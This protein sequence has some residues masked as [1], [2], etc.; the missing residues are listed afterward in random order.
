MKIPNPLEMNDWDIRKFFVIFITLYVIF[1]GIFF[2]DKL[3]INIPIVEE[4]ITI[5]TLIFVPGILFLRTLRLHKL[6]S[7]KT[8]LLT[9]GSSLSIIMAIGFF[10]NL[11]LLQFSKTPLTNTNLTISLFIILIFLSFTTY[12]RDR[13][14]SNPS[15]IQIHDLNST[16]FY[17]SILLFFLVIIGTY[18]MNHWSLNYLLVICI[19]MIPIFV[20]AVAFDKISN[21]FYPFILFIISIALLYHT[22]LISNYIWGYDI[23]IEYNLANSIIA[24]SFWNYNIPI[25]INAMLSTAILGPFIVKITNINLVWTYKIIFPFI[26]SLVPLGM[27]EITKEQTNEKIGFLSSFFFISFYVFFIEM[28][29]LP[30]QQIAEFFL[31]LI[32]ILILGKQANYKINVLI[33]IFTLSIIVSH[34]ATSYIV[35]F[36]FLFA[37]LILKVIKYNAKNLNRISSSI[38]KKLKIRN[39]MNFPDKKKNYK[40]NLNYIILFI[41]MVV[42]WYIFISSSI[43]YNMFLEISNHIVTNLR[44]DFLSPSST[45]SIHI[46]NR[47][48]NLIQRIETFLYLISQFCIFIGLIS[49]FLKFKKFNFKAEYRAIAYVTFLFAIAG[50]I[51]PNFGS[52]INVS[53]LFHIT[54]IF[55]AP[56]CV[57]GGIFLLQKFFKIKNNSK[58]LKVF[59]LLVIIFFIFNTKFVYEITDNN[60]PTPGL[61]ENYDYSLFNDMEVL[62]AKW[63]SQFKEIKLYDDIPPENGT[64]RY[65][66]TYIYADGYRILLLASVGID[67][68]EMPSN[69]KTIPRESY[70]FL[71]T[72][73]IKQNTLL[74][75]EPPFISYYKSSNGLVNNL[76]KIYDNGGSQ[77][78]Y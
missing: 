34:Y 70:L 69:F 13:K 76:N 44:D 29:Q 55:L 61:N 15:F 27:Y 12:I 64:K 74:F 24:Q 37:W 16:F 22:S 33:V 62:G 19:L 66:K 7:L 36:I 42:V 65:R 57:I 9:I 78:F 50:V 47:S 11:L 20:L 17:L 2:L 23:M 46:V 14:Y 71:G 75:S 48:G 41:S 39:L 25:T 28:F 56:F 59:S 73:N 38:S 18:Y 1:I 32:L 67:F 53:R 40:L 60:A 49:I 31:V 43:N 4:L 30:R 54:L 8:F 26:F 45:Q 72:K 58:A 51:V 68:L 35:M 63:L 10:S 77:I 21:K 3:G 5:I 6:G 52:T